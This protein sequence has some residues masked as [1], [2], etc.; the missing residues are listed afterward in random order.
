MIGNK[1]MANYEIYD[2][3][4]E[5]IDESNNLLDAQIAAEYLNAKFILDTQNNKII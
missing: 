5:V 3:N 1:N 4:D 2:E